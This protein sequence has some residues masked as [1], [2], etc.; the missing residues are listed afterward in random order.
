[1]Q[2]HHREQIENAAKTTAGFFDAKNG[3]RFSTVSSHQLENF[4]SPLQSRGDG[5]DDREYQQIDGQLVEA[6]ADHQLKNLPA[7]VHWRV[8][9]SGARSAG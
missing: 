1:M 4:F 6:F 2:K 7:A 8:G 5:H 9:A 3:N